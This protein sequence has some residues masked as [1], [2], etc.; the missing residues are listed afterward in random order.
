MLCAVRSGAVTHFVALDSPNPTPPYTSWDTAAHVIQDA[1]DAADTN[2]T[3]LVTN[4]LYNTGGRVV[5]GTLTNRIAI[6]KPLI[7]QSVN[8]PDVT[9]IEGHQIPGITNG[10]GAI[11]CVY[12]TNDT[13]LIGFTIAH[14]AT[15][16]NDASPSDLGIGGVRCD[17]YT[18]SILTNC[19]IIYNSSTVGAGG[20][21]LGTLNN[22]LIASNSTGTY[23]GGV[24]Y[25]TLNR[26]VVKGNYAGMGDAGAAGNW[27]GPYR[28]NYWTSLNYCTVVGNSTP[29]PA[30]G[31][32]GELLNN[33]LI[34]CNQASEGGGVINGQLIN[35][36]VVSNSAPVGAGLAYCFAKNSIVYY[37]N[38]PD[39]DSFTGFHNSCTPLLLEP[40][41]GS[42]TTEPLFVNP[43]AGDFHLQSNSPCI[44]TGDNALLV[45]TNVDQ[46]NFLIFMTNSIDG[47]PRVSG[48][49]VDI[50]AYE[51]QSPTSKISYAWLQQNGFALD[52]SAD[53]VDSDGDGMSNWQEW[54]AGTLPFDNTSLLSMLCPAITATGATLTWQS[55]PNITY[56]LQRAAQPGAPFMTIQSNIVGQTGTTSYTDT[57]AVGNGPFFYRVGV[58]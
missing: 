27:G 34:I 24:V 54:R 2:D 39:A 8:G 10:A 9:I 20:V 1:I 25:S 26:C 12:M 58:Q 6:T 4:G 43:A 31:A 53:D 13:T 57:N 5:Y 50:G 35:C 29:G 15:E 48:G 56:F 37:N 41:I 23:G 40:E 51:F 38:G 22:C 28:T 45:Y 46:G 49:T 16:T 52:G 47:K 19:V 44:N 3:V 33:C 42:I 36:T 32:D 55:Q 14:G 11:R 18:N 21:Y 7:V 17:N 30:G